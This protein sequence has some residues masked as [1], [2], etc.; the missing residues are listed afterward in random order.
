[1]LEKRIKMVNIIILG[2]F[3]LVP[4]YRVESFQYYSRSR[5]GVATI[6]QNRLL[7]PISSRQRFSWSTLHENRRVTSS[8][9][10]KPS[11]HTI[12]LIVKS[13]SLISLSS[14]LSISKPFL[15]QCHAK[16]ISLTFKSPVKGWGLLGRVPHDDYLFTTSRLIDPDLLK[17]QISEVVSRSRFI[18]SFFSRKTHILLIALITAATGMEPC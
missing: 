3:L 5:G 12:P 8:P 7:K 6:Q 18:S 14:I 1:M 9:S 13:L 4:V 11:A 17:P 10:L 16:A 2:L 15:Q